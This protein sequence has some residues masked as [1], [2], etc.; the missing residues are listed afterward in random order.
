MRFKEPRLFS[1]CIIAFVGMVILAMQ[2]FILHDTKR[3]IITIILSFM[4]LTLVL[5]RFN[6]L[7][8]DDFMVI[9]TFK[10]I[11]ILPMMLEYKDIIEVYSTSKMKVK[12]KTNKK[13]YSIYVFNVS[14]FKEA[15][16]TNTNKLN[17][18]ITY[19]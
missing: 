11:G 8:S 14:K 4:A 3:L 19:H 9:Y 7:L 1:I 2:S 15:L 5:G 10:Y 16:Q 18:D 17:L 13:E 12:I 6:I